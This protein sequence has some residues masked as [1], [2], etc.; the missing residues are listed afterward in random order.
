MIMNGNTP[1]LISGVPNVA[2]SLATI[3][4]QASATPER[5]RQHVP[6]RRADRRLAELQDRAGTAA[7]S[8]RCRSACARA[9]RRRRTGRGCRRREKTFSCEE[10]EHHAAHALVVARRSNAA[11]SSLSSSLESALRVSGVFSVIGRDAV[12]AHVVEDRLVGHAAIST[13]VG[14]GASGLTCPGRS[15]SAPTG[16]TPPRCARVTGRSS[17]QGSGGAS[18]T[19]SAPYEP[20]PAPVGGSRPPA[21]AEWAISPHFKVDAVLDRAP[22]VLGGPADIEWRCTARGRRRVGRSCRGRGGGGRPDR[23]RQQ[24]HAGRRRVLGSMPN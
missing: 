23:A 20:A 1:T 21:A 10:V 14:A 9:A 8:A 12:V 22:D 24:G 13:S 16:P 5:A 15:A 4:S 3:R 18:C 11:I 6:V 7:G 17:S 2:L 19:W